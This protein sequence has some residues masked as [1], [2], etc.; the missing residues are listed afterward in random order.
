MTARR[1]E[2]QRRARGTDIKKAG[3]KPGFFKE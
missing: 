2:N 1:H 3:P